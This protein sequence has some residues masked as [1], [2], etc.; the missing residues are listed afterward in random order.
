MYILS[1]DVRTGK[2]IPRRDGAAVQPIDGD[3]SARAPPVVVIRGASWGCDET[4][5]HP[6]PAAVGLLE[7]QL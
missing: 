7:V 4:H 3:A 2:C 5:P 1:V 6:Q